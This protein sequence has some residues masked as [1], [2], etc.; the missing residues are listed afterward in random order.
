MTK[1]TTPLEKEEQI[2]FVEYCE[3]NGI[4]AV[5]TQNGFKMPKTAFNYAAYSRTLKKMGL[6][7]GFPDLIIFEKNK[8]KSH[9]VLMIE[10]K[11]QKGGKLHAEQEEWLQKLDKKDYCVGVAKGC[12]SAIRILQKYLNS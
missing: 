11:R 9:E 12:E 1:N 6:S 5:S 8:S 3:V 10:M 4:C 7:K 2:A